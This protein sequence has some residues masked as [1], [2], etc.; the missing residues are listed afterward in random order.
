MLERI[1]QQA[2]LKDVERAKKRGKNLQKLKTII[3]MLLEQKQLPF[4][5]KNHKLK[6][7]FTD[8]WECHIE[9]NWL[10]IYKKTLS[11][12]T[13]VRNGTHADLF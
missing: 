4:K 3:D 12:I 8:C 5:Y 6:G 2:F 7:I 9:P 10:L 13:L 11:A 1:Y